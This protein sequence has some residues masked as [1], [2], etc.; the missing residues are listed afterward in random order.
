MSAGGFGLICA[1]LAK[2]RYGWAMF[3]VTIVSI[4]AK[5]WISFDPIAV[6]AHLLGLLIGFPLKN[7]PIARRIAK[8]PTEP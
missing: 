4:F 6:A 2:H 3:A 7:S 1:L 8:T 5:I